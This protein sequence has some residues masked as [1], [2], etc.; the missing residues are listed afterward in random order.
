MVARREAR[1]LARDGARAV[2]ATQY[3]RAPKGL[4]VDGFVGDLH[5][6]TVHAHQPPA[7]VPS[8]FGGRHRNRLTT[9]SCNCCSGSHP[10]RVRACEIPELLA[11][12]SVTAGSSNRCTPSS[13]ETP[14]HFA[15]GQLHVQPQ[16][17]GLIDHHM[18]RQVPLTLT[19]FAGGCQRLARS[20]ASSLL[21]ADVAGDAARRAE[22]GRHRNH[23]RAL[24]RP[25][26]AGA[27]CRV[28]PSAVMRSPG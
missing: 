28:E 9:A 27:R 8:P 4:I 7:A 19:G 13:A 5:G 10:N 26:A 1:P 2:S 22:R 11:T 18:S 14:Q 16:G 3:S 21:R 6:A 20:P 25:G 15:V 12:L 17:N 24:P 23:T